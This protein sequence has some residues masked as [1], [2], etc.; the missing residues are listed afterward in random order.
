MFYS[1][2]RLVGFSLSPDSQLAEGRKVLTLIFLRILTQTL[3][4]PSMPTPVWCH[5]QDLLDPSTLRWK[6]L[7]NFLGHWCLLPHNS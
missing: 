5:W 6:L 3:A 4:C 2:K 7:Q 1:C